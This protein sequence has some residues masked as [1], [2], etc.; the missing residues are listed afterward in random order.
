MLITHQHPHNK[1]IMIALLGKPNAGKS[2]LIN[3]LLGFDLS[4]VS[5]KPQT[6]RNRINC[7]FTVDR[8]EVVLVDTPG[9]HSS[10]QEMNIR[11]NG[12]AYGGLEGAD[13]NFILVDSRYDHF[14]EIKEVID[15]L[16][17]ELGRTWILFNK[18]D[19]EDKRDQR[20]QI[21][22]K[23]QK[24]YPFIEKIFFVSAKTG[25][26][27]HLLTG[28]IVDQ[29]KPGPHLYYDGSV[30]NKNMRF[31]AAEYIREQ[32]FRILKEEIPY[33]V[34]VVIDE[35]KDIEDWQD[36]GDGKKPIM[37][38]IE[39][40]ILVN[41][42]SQ[43]AIVVGRGGSVIKEI[44]IKAREKIG[45]M[46]GGDIFLKLHVKVTPKWFKNNMILEELGLPRVKESVRI[47]RKK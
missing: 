25:D 43:R 31:F 12:Q 45:A 14:K 22:E 5:N 7:A 20:D 17:T 4:I 37:A 47:W 23:L 15:S 39:A 32:A 9:L 46:L 34:A 3:Q 35:Y 29:A 30:S 18:S 10:N 38:K 2:T 41:R 1:S 24:E 36:R 21:L 19:I 26:D 13:I 44:G 28:D 42:P 8:T 40:T 11:M 33:E 16:H 6:T 27:I